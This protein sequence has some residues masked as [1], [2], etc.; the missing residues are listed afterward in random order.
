[1]FCGVSK[2]KRHFKVSPKPLEAPEKP[3]EDFL[4]LAELNSKA[5]QVQSQAQG[6]RDSGAQADSQK[7][8]FSETNNAKFDMAV[9]ILEFVNSTMNEVILDFFMAR[10]NSSFRKLKGYSITAELPFALKD[11]VSS[12][13]VCETFQNMKNRFFEQCDKPNPKLMLSRSDPFQS[14]YF[15]Q[16]LFEINLRNLSGV[17]RELKIANWIVSLKNE[18]DDLEVTNDIRKDFRRLI[19]SIRLNIR[20][21]TCERAYQV[22]LGKDDRRA[23]QG[24]VGGSWV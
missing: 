8:E 14:N 5:N 15:E 19:C 13:D 16:N 21:V 9:E 12:K 20:Q 11:K 1:M 10:F 22:R 4:V 23:V 7:R 6:P 2:L 3:A 18:V 24:V 17:S